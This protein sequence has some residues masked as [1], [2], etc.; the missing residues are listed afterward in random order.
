M[1]KKDSYAS[2]VKA[3][4]SAHPIMPSV[5]RSGETG[6]NVHTKVR[7]TTKREAE[8]A[9]K[10]MIRPLLSLKWLSIDPQLKLTFMAER[11]PPSS[12]CPAGT[13]DGS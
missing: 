11:P 10:Y 8:R 6:F 3:V 5:G 9:G 2:V 13:L 7:T 1:E 4:D 12:N